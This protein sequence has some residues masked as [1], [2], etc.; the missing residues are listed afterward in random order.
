MNIF[1]L[2]HI[3]VLCAQMH[4][5]KHIVKMP[6]ETTQMLCSVHYMVESTYSPPYK[7]THKNHPC[8]IWARASLAN[9][10]WLC[11]LGKELCREYTLRYK[12]VHKCEQY[13]DELAKNPPP[14]PDIGLTPLAQAMPDMYKDDDPIVAYRHY[15]AFDKF[16]LH[17]WKNRDP[18]EWID[19]LIGVTP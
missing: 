8:S 16:H 15:Y 19:E 5:D 12:R 11:E 14:I 2:H 10:M 7:L 17:S 6:L 9:Y 4:V 18:P 1:Y 13:I 3:A